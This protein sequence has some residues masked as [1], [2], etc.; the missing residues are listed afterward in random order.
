MADPTT[1]GA[2]V[3]PDELV[4][5]MYVEAANRGEFDTID[6]Y[7][8]AQRFAAWGYTRAMQDR[9]ELAEL[10]MAQAAIATQQGRAMET[11]EPGDMSHAATIYET[12]DRAR[13]WAERLRGGDRDG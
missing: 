3:P 7:T 6:R 11:G 12:V 13:A 2:P 10:L 4:D 5:Q 9:Q 8:I 1:P